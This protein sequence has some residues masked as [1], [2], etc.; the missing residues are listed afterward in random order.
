MKLSR[1]LKT[2]CAAT[3]VT[4]LLTACATA[5]QEDTAA[6]PAAP[7]TDDKLQLFATTGYLAD[8]LH[9]IAPDAEI[10][11]LVGP[12]SD[13]HTY[14]PT[15]SDINTMRES[16]L[17]F[18]NGLHLEAQMVTPLTSLGDK[19]LAV[20]EHVDESKLIPVSDPEAPEMHFD[21]HIWNDPEIW[22]D[23]VDLMADK[24]ATTDT[25]NADTYKANAAKYK[26]EI[27]AADQQAQAL[28]S[29]VP[30]PR[31]LV[32]GHDAFNYFGKYYGLEVHATDFI[33][34][35]AARSATEIEE[36]AK[37]IS[38]KKIPAI[39]QD[40]QAN[41]QAITSLS[42]AVA[43]R[44]WQVRVVEKEL[45]ADTL[46]AEP[47]VDTYLEVLSHNTQTIAEALK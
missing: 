47:E 29:Q 14:Q 1:M 10:I 44:G 18:W 35:T 24:L 16:D 2:F 36:L 27:A 40:T 19:Q 17:I 22:Q 41:P 26:A 11:T 8:A 37:L 45:Y 21:P 33:S 9:N 28:L 6:T 31:T 46:G 15:T 4:G 42:E 39:F 38:D 12:G 30:A 23:V 3:L 5:P 7:Q 13:P 32:T 20:G 25:A 43:A 34:T